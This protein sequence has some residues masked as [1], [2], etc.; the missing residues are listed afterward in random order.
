MRDVIKDGYAWYF[1][2]L[3]RRL[4][5]SH[6]CVLSINIRHTAVWEALALKHLKH[7]SNIIARPQLRAVAA[8]P[9]KKD[10]VAKL[11]YITH[12]QNGCHHIFKVMHSR[13]EKCGCNEHFNVKRSRRQDADT[14][15]S[16]SKFNFSRN[17]WN[18]E[19]CYFGLRMLSSSFCF[20]F[21][22]QRFL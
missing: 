19:I 22:I 5:L 11:H 16:V 6:P 9:Q 17:L 20:F 13:Q 18:F 15:Y 14:V 8:P 3:Y 2:L 4:Q 10:S 12:V 7:L 1:A 21:F